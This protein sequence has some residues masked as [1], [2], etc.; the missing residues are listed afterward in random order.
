MGFYIWPFIITDASLSRRCLS[1]LALQSWLDQLRVWWFQTTLPRL[2]LVAEPL[3][4]QSRYPFNF[5]PWYHQSLLL[6]LRVIPKQ[7]LQLF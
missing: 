6:T 7:P 5:Q 2:H 1:A 3:N 4:D